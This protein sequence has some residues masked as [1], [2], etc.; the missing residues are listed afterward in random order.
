MLLGEFREGKKRAISMHQHRLPPLT[1][2]TLADLRVT[3]VTLS[4]G[5]IVAVSTLFA[6]HRTA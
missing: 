6:V 3:L 1:S 4:P 2:L 5:Q